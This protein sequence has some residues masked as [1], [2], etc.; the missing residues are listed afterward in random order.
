M[1]DNAADANAYLRRNVIM[2]DGQPAYVHEVH[3]S[4]KGGIEA[5]IQLLP[6]TDARKLETVDIADKRF[7]CRL[8]NLGYMLTENGR[9]FYVSRLPS[10]EMPQGLA[11]G[12]L[13][14]VSTNRNRID[15]GNALYDKGFRDMLMGNYMSPKD[16]LKTLTDNKAATGVCVSPVLAVTRH[17]KFKDLLFLEYKG[18]E[19]SF[20]QTLEFSL[21][22]EFKHLA[23]V[24][25]PTG[26]LKAA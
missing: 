12:N 25:Q 5:S 7:N 14:F 8:Y 2:W 23:E 17:A 3:A 19:V 11:Q 16:T 1:F 26:L 18:K 24:C 10:R 22:S 21:P 13:K 15:F 6:L 9:L 20:S 4:A